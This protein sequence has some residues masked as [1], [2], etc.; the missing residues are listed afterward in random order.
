M[1]KVARTNPTSC[2]ITEVAR[3][4]SDTWTMLILHYLGE[5]PKRFC[6]LELALGGISTRTLTL[7]LIKLIQDGMVIKTEAGVYATTKKGKGIKLIE[8]AM[9][10]YQEKYL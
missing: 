6:E 4:L 8:Q 3:L 9:K 1:K 5:G 2:P 10:K 7:K